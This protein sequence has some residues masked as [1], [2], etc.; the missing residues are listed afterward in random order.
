MV[1]VHKF[2]ATAVKKNFKTIDIY[3]LNVNNQTINAK[4][5]VKLLRIEINK[6]LYLFINEKMK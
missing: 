4:N 2:Q 3:P 1:N 5:C 6:N